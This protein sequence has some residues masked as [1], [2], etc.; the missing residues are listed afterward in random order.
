MRSFASEIY[1]ESRKLPTLELV[2]L[3]S[4]TDGVVSDL[5]VD[6]ITPERILLHQESLTAM[7]ALFESDGGRA[8]R[9]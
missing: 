4:D 7:L 1:K 9:R 8:N 3:H 2:P 6:P 5:A